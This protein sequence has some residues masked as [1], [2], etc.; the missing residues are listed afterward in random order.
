MVAPNTG[1]EL[2]LPRVESLITKLGLCPLA[3]PS[4][5]QAEDRELQA[6]GFA[7]PPGLFPVPRGCDSPEETDHYREGV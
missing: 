6:P 5:E 7:L 1:L 4:R 3:M 2:L